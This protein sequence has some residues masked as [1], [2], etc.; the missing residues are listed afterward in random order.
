MLKPEHALFFCH[1]V[2]RE[3]RLEWPA[4]VRKTG[5]VEFGIE[6]GGSSKSATAISVINPT[7]GL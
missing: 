1:T 7:F 5:A 2:S 6:G 4:G 3:R